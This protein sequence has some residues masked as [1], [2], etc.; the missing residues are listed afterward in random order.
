MKN[1]TRIVLTAFRNFLDRQEVKDKMVTA[2]MPVDARLGDLSGKEVDV[3]LSTVFQGMTSKLSFKDMAKVLDD[4]NDV[5]CVFLEELSC[6]LQNYVP[7][8][9][10]PEVSIENKE[11]DVKNISEDLKKG[12]SGEDEQVE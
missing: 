8:V 1:E 4:N 9:E 7:P 6:G 5:V 12:D 3:P 2:T 10:E 11:M